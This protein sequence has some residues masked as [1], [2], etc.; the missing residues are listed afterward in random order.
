[1]TAYLKSVIAVVFCAALLCSILPKERAGKIT[2]FAV[3]LVVVTVILLPLTRL[4][5]G[6]SPSLSKLQV[7]SL[8]IGGTSY[9]MDE[10]EK[11]VASRTEQVLQE[12]TGKFFQVSVQSRTDTDGKIC[13]IAQAEIM[14]YTTEYAHIAATELGI[15]DSKV[16][17]MK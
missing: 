13:G 8:Q 2:N 6:I 17:E 14:P 16:V 15:A 9:L 4:S 3:G 1:M 10:F 5:R 7:Q 11:T 12:K